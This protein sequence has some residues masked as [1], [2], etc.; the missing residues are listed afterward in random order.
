MPR[1]SVCFFFQKLFIHFS[2]HFSTVL[3]FIVLLAFKFDCIF[4]I[5]TLWQ[6]GGLKIL[7]HFLLHISSLIISFAVQIFWILYGLICLICCLILVNVLSMKSSPK[8]IS[9]SASLAFYS[10][11][12][13]ISYLK[14][15]VFLK[16]Y[17]KLIFATCERYRSNF[18]FLHI[19]FHFSSTI[20]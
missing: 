9:W 8:E 16:I 20:C 13:I 1:A 12:F 4:E 14:F 3:F 6:K 5:F 17:P 11:S 18:T 7:F 2:V 15:R 19:C 10:S